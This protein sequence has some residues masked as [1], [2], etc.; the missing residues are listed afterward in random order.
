M[1]GFHQRLLQLEPHHQQAFMAALCER[2]LPNYGLYAETTGQ[3]DLHGLRVILDLV[4]ERLAVKE[5]RIDFD[6]QAEKL[7]ELEP[8][9]DD[10]S[11]GARRA[12]EAVVAL[13]AL[14]DTLRGD[15]LD[16]VLEVSRT[17]KGGVRAFI[18]LTEGEE[19]AQRLAVLVKTH[20]LMEEENDF[21]DAV[22]EAVEQSPLDR[23]NLKA[24]RRLG[25]NEGV[26]NLG[27]SLD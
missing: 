26:S 24:L 5:A 18:E 27:L 2:L 17:S 7:A 9:L 13:S 19:D 14:L 21:Q 15:A 10:D 6:R 23:D 25:R 8:P 12:L 4:W 1:S 11:F 16:A 22:L 20:P 3:G